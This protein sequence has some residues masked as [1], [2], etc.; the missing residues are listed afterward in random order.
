MFNLLFPYC[1]W[2]L[3][4]FLLS[5]L[6]VCMCV[7]D[8]H[9][10]INYYMCKLLIM[11]LNF[12]PAS[13]LLKFVAVFP[14]IPWPFYHITLSVIGVASYQF[15]RLK[16]TWLAAPLVGTKLLVPLP[17]V[18]SLLL[19]PRRSPL[20][21]WGSLRLTASASVQLWFTWQLAPGNTSR[22]VW[23]WKEWEEYK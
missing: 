1:K 10:C 17:S 15:L 4:S 5:V 2:R 12:I 3:P 23:M 14:L 21:P 16:G 8:T 22:G 20:F 11:Y 13:L 9:F 6:F 19:P 18:S 7:Y